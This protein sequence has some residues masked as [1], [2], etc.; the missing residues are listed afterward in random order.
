MSI[1][2][3]ENRIIRTLTFHLKQFANK[4]AFLLFDNL[5]GDFH[6]L[7]ISDEMQNENMLKTLFQPKYK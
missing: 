3:L 4:Y 1:I 5:S 6:F 2:S 7:I